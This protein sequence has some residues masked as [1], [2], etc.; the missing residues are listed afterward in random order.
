MT[1]KQ[2]F[3]EN[4]HLYVSS[5]AHS[6]TDDLDLA[7]EKLGDPDGWEVLDVAT[8]TGHTAFFFS[9]RLAHVFA[10]D[11]NDEMLE[12]AQEESDRRSLACRFLKGAADEL[13]FDDE[14]FDLVTCRLAAHHFQDPAA[15]LAEGHRVLRPGGRLLLID[16]IVPIGSAGKWINE[17]ETR[18]DPSHVACL[19]EKAW[20]DLFQDSGFS[21]IELQQFPREL[22]FETWMERMSVEQHDREVAWEKLC[23]AP[24]EVRD[25]FQP[26]EVKGRR[27]TLHRLIALLERR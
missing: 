1:S 17:F 9:Q 8:G 7:L 14:T 23:Q 2:G 26:Q 20:K 10:V 6:Q 4:A 11:I 13:P 5:L 22:D 18:R 27:F 24:S 21:E 25:F 3:S 15:F 16:N 19:T 12:V